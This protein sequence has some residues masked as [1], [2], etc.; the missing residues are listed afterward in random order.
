MAMPGPS[1]RPPSYVNANPHSA[2]SVKRFKNLSRNAQVAVGA[3]ALVG[4]LLLLPLLVFVADEMRTNGEVARNVS[5]GGVELGGLGEE[6]AL[7]VLR[8]YEGELASAELQYRVADDLFTIRPREL[9]LDIAEE[10]IV[11]EAMQQ[12]R[13][14]GFFSRFTSW[15]GTF[16]DQIELDVQ[17]AYDPDRL[18]DLLD[19]WEQE[20]INEPAFEGGIVVADGRVLPEYPRPGE[21]ID[22]DAAQQATQRVLQGVDRPVLTL[23][24]RD[25]EPVITQADIDDAVERAT[26]I[27]DSAIVLQ[28]NDPEVEIEFPAETLARALVAEVRATQPPRVDLGFSR[29][30]IAAVLE[31]FRETIEQPPRD[32]EYLIDEE[33]QVTLRPSRPQTLLDVDLVIDRLFEVADRGGSTGTFPFAEGTPAGFTTEMAEAMGEITK[34]SE[35]TTEHPCCQDRVTNI[36]TMAKAVD[37]AIVMP[38]E[39]FDLNGHVGER[40]IEKGYVPAPM[41]L[42]GEIVDDVGGGVSQFA[43][44]L[45]NAMFFGCYEDVDHQPHSYYFSRYPEGR[46]A[47]V[48]W[49]GPE[50][51]FRNDTESILIVKTA[52]TSRSITVKMFGNT[53]GRECKA[54]LGD[55][56]RYVDPPIEYE[57]D[58][59]LPPGVEV[60]EQKGGRGWSIDYFRYIF[61]ADGTDETQV[62]SHRYLPSSNVIRRHPCSMDDAP[63]PCNV[64]VPDVVGLKQGK[65]TSNLETWGFAVVKESV[66]VTDQDQDSVVQSQTPAGGSPQRLGGTVVIKVGNYVEP[67]G[68]VASAVAATAVFPQ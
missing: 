39:E 17:V 68:D 26:R 16:G 64:T 29:Q 8:A 14:E 65:A 23:A 43:T 41:I 6:D 34:V 13:E 59:S 31:P 3:A 28:A 63:D 45:F 56:Y 60:E 47:T 25:I 10:E 46:E 50:L 36:Q 12:R 62:W 22:R 11:A 2:V 38:G 1:S 18:D 54:G 15:F 5:A 21:G 52:F 4:L 40:T 67:E 49:G 9:D 19:A 42:R 44:T 32:A 35:F 53:G 7:T 57:E 37:G 30:P 61:Y 33:D 51:I 20:A 55:R 24:T 48:S 66:D 58:P 27:V